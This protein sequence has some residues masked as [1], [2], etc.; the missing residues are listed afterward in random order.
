MSM[1]IIG[2]IV[3]ASSFNAYV[4]V[5]LLTLFMYCFILVIVGLLLKVEL[6]TQKIKSNRFQKL[7]RACVFIIFFIYM[8]Y[9]LLI[10]KIIVSVKCKCL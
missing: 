10:I 1:S 7:S 3:C 9:M 6:N 5:R 4:N 8:S 2:F